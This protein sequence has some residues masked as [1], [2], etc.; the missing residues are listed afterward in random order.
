MKTLFKYIIALLLALP[1]GGVGGGFLYAQTATATDV[2]GSTTICDDAVVPVKLDDIVGLAL[3]AGGGSWA[4]VDPADDS[5]IAENVSNI[6]LGIDRLPGVYKFIFTPKNNPCMLDDDRAIV[7]IT[8]VSVP[9]ALNHY[10][11]LCEGEPVSLDLT[12][13]LSETVTNSYGVTNIKFYDEDDVELASSIVNYTT[14]GEYHYTYSV[15]ANSASCATSAPIAVSV[16]SYGVSDNI[17]FNDSVTYCITEMPETVNLHAKLGFTSSVGTWSTTSGLSVSSE[18]I[19]TL[20][21]ASA[22]N[23]YLFTYSYKNCDNEDKN[24]PFIIS[25]TAD[26]SS[27]YDAIDDTTQICKTINSA[28]F[29]NLM[30]VIGLD[31]PNTAGSWHVQKEV[32]PVDVADGIF[33]IADARA[34]EYTYTFKVSNAVDICAIAGEA[35]VTVNVFDSGEVLDGEVQLCTANMSGT[36]DLNEFMPSLPAGGV[37]SDNETAIT[38]DSAFDISSLTLGVHSLTYTFD[39]GPCGAAEAQ[40]LVVVSD[41][42]TNFKNKTKKYCLTDEGTDAIDLDQVLGV[43]NIAGTWTTSAPHFD[44]T[45]HVFNG[46]EAGINADGTDA[47]YTFTFTASESGCG[48]E[49][50]Q[51]VVITIIIT[52]DLS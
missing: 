17:E 27:S 29:V 43:G 36:I 41:V 45:T 15:P 32:S 31:L 8:V 14:E 25:I 5:V 42:I 23:N 2:E 30:D 11:A 40:L 50:G 12:T 20:T 18:G 21:G 37:W 3:S 46:R 48:V 9:R 44:E 47:S 1:L 26:L 19:A 22:E 28:G 33:E 39:A 35:T 6:F 10:V 34:G 16:V 4:E 52:E 7:T 51:E 13:L 49:A 24:F 38:D